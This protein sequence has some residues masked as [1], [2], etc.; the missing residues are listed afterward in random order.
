MTNG[1]VVVACLVSGILGASIHTALQKKPSEPTCPEPKVSEPPAPAPTGNA[2][3]QFRQAK[4]R[5]VAAGITPERAIGTATRAIGRDADGCT[6]A[7][8]RGARI[9]TCQWDF[10]DDWI[11]VTDFGGVFFSDDPR[12][13]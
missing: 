12:R 7:N 6:T 1:R 2:V 9:N 11:R 3:A 4:V 5:V 13:K 10:G 8:V